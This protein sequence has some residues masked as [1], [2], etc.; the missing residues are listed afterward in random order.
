MIDH[1]NPVFSPFS[2][3]DAPSQKTKDHDLQGCLKRWAN[4]K[5][6]ILRPFLAKGEGENPVPGYR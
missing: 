1:I 2:H 3:T 4:Q 5:R 6:K